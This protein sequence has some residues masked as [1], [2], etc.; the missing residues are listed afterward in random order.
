MEF[1]TGNPEPGQFYI[2]QVTGA[3]KKLPR[4]NVELTKTLK[5]RRISGP[6]LSEQ[7]AKQQKELKLLRENFQLE[8]YVWECQRRESLAMA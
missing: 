2:S 1:Q 6:F 3:Q 8:S 7:E 5:Y 4:S